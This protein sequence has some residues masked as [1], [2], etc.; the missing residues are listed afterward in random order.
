LAGTYDLVLMDLQMPGTDGIETCRQ[1]RAQEAGR[2]TGI[3]AMTAHAGPEI[4]QACLDAGMDGFLTKPLRLELLVA[5]VGR[6]GDA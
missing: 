1:I 2:H 5:L 6:L 3:Y 4:E